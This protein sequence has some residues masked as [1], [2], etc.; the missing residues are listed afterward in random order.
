MGE[1]RS[2]LK[3][4]KDFFLLACILLESYR[5]L[6][7]CGVFLLGKKLKHVLVFESFWE[8]FLLLRKIWKYLERF[9]LL[10]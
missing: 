2:D 7:L 1:G 8:N 10:T 9:R 4:K 5:T 6:R 3:L